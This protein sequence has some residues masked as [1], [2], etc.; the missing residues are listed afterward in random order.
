[1]RVKG[2][3]RKNN[4][5]LCVLWRRRASQ[6]QPQEFDSFYSQAKQVLDCAE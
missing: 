1:M 6:Q 3:A 5:N 2:S 4:D